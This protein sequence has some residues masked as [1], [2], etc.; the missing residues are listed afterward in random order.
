MDIRDYNNMDGEL[1]STDA[2]LALSPV[3][4]VP[5]NGIYYYAEGDF[6]KKT[7]VGR[8]ARYV[9]QVAVARGVYNLAKGTPEGRQRR[10][11][12]RQQRRDARTQSK[13]NYSQ[14]QLESAKALGK[15]S[16]LDKAL[17]GS[18]TKKSSGGAKGLSTTTWVVIG[19]V[20]VVALVGGFFLIKK[21]RS[22]AK[23]GK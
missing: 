15:E 1:I 4:N 6:F 17:A 7:A 19:V 8:V 22:G 2:Q 20:G 23:S 16:S 18:L 21:A 10:Q 13:L 12:A 11:Q 9:P 14:A 3:G 5:E